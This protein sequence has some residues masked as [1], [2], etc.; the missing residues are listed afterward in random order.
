MGSFGA[1]QSGSGNLP[2]QACEKLCLLYQVIKNQSHPL[3]SDFGFLIPTRLRFDRIESGGV[4]WVN[5]LPDI[6]SVRVP[7]P[8]M[9]YKYLLSCRSLT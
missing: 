8:G 3:M 2:E 4:A 6:L 7:I 5:R 1:H 9:T